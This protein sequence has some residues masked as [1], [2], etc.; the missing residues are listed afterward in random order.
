MDPC[1]WLKIGRLSRIFYCSFDRTSIETVLIV[2]KRLVSLW[3]FLLVV[4]N[5]RCEVKESPSYQNVLSK[6]SLGEE[7]G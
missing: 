1:S 6:T 5:L 3:V 2:V 4:N 7:A